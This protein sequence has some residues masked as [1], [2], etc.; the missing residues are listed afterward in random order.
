M[1]KLR[2]RLFLIVGMLAVVL[3]TAAAPAAAATPAPAS[4]E[5]TSAVWPKI[6]VKE[7]AAGSITPASA[8]SIVK[9]GYRGTVMCEAIGLEIEWSAG[10]F[11]YFDISTNRSIWH[12]WPNSGGWKVMPGN[13]SADHIFDAY[14]AGTSR[15]VCVSNNSNGSVWCSTDP[16]TSASW[17]SWW[18]KY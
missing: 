2:E 12:V 6:T 17:G 16:P 1:S 15:V 8:C 14:W 11:E 3:G 18:R 5:A 4:A 7:V 10:R 13:G 9:Y